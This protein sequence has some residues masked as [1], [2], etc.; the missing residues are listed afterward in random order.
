MRCDEC[1]WWEKRT[2]SASRGRFGAC[3]RRAPPSG[4][5]AI[6]QD[7]QGDIVFVDW[8]LTHKGD[9]CGEFEPRPKAKA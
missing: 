9:W 5:N 6:P 7:D 3:R 8:P 4:P 2:G 1:K